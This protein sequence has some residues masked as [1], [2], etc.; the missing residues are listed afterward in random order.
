MERIG[1]PAAAGHF[2]GR[3]S[4]LSA[5]L[6]GA[7]AATVA[8]PARA[9]K[10]YD[11]GASD[12]EIR[13]GQTQPYGGPVSAA[14]G[15]GHAS[16][17]YFE[18]VNKRGGINGRKVNLLSLDDGYSP[19][20]TV[21]VTRK[22]VED[23]KVL[24]IYGSTGT[25]TNAA[26]Q[27]YLNVKKVPQ[28]FVATGAH[29]FKDPKQAP[30]TIGML[31]SYEAEGKALAR[32]VLQA[33]AAPKI[34]ILY[35]NDD[36]GKDFVRGFKEGLGS[37]AASLVVSEQSFEVTDPSLTSQMLTARSSG[38][39]VLFY[40]G[41]QKYGAMQFKTRYGM[42]WS[43]LHVVCSTSSGLETVLKPAGLE[44][45]QGVISTAYAKDPLDPSWKDEADVREYMDFVKTNLPQSNPSDTGIILGYMAS[46]L[47]EQVLKTAG[48]TL[49]RDHVMK[50]A[51]QLKEVKLPMLLPGIAVNT[52]P[53]DY[54]VLGRFQI[55]R[56]E[57]TRWT[58]VGT[59]ISAE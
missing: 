54:G 47:M 27:K 19:P 5:L 39:N 45:V 50:V 35:Q 2:L 7:L 22:L 28:L 37:K 16:R 14:A 1:I 56:F 44:T 52:G 24:L 41:T 12:T 8:R 55:Q 26:V 25:P 34:A 42:G 29:R 58:R 23:D 43:P 57:G 20:K 53:A 15:V 9:Q 31:P 21:E 3:R 46:A 18:A 40:A 38:A 51:T 17:A 30:W 33:E 4:S 48:D 11:P 13:L 36:L 6:A 10:A 59:P 49:T 32:Y